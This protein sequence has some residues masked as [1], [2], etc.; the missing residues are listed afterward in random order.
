[1]ASDHLADWLT[2]WH[3]VRE[4]VRV[5]AEVDAVHEIAAITDRLRTAQGDPAIL[6]DHVR[7]QTTSVVT[8]LLGSPRRLS[9][10]FGVSS[11]E[12]WLKVE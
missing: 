6:F 9:A 4:L 2:Q 12:R 8:N 5:S 1:M 7:G 11:P 3:D 10:A